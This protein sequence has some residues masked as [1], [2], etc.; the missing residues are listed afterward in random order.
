LVKVDRFAGDIGANIADGDGAAKGWEYDGNA[1]P[2]DT[3]DVSHPHL[4]GGDAG[5]GIS[6]GNNGIGLASFSELC[7]NSDG[8]FYFLS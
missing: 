2:V 6:G 3:F 8:T 5:A 4:K 1:G 7:D